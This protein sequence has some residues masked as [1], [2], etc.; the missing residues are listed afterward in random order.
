MKRFE[1]LR[2]SRFLRVTRLVKKIKLSSNNIVVIVKVSNA[3]INIKYRSHVIKISKE[4]IRGASFMIEKE[5][6]KCRV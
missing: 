5:A 3:K 4:G 2:P 6:Y 1:A